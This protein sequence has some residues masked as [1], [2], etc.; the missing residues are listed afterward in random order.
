MLRGV[1]R[2]HG[3]SGEFEVLRCTEC[4]SARTLPYVPPESLGELYPDDYTAY[5]FPDNPALR[6][7]AVS[8]SEARYWRAVRSE[9][10]NRLRVGPRGRVLDVGSGRGDL[11]LILQR[12]GWD[13]LGLEP[14]G[15]A[16][17]EAAERGVPTVHATLQSAGADLEGPFD[18]V[19]FNHSLEH[20]T[21][22]IDD[23]RKARE[24]LRDGGE[25][26]VV[27]PNFGSWQRVRFGTFWF[28][29]DLPRHRSHFTQ[30][31]LSRLLGRAGFG[32]VVTGTTGTADGLPMSLQYRAF[33]RRRFDHG[34]GRYAALGA[35]LAAVPL[36]S[37]ANRLAGSGDIAHAVATK[38]AG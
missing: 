15:P 16:C 30:L 33:G 29:L 23:V 35:T 27:V 6:L 36:T 25:L 4:G 17:A 13:V 20:V 28:H 24:L 37:L 22:P 3:T 18:V 9:P 2:L 32:D 31:G 1:D 5:A 7:L 19:V 10:L 14:S 12:L 34:V 11:G 26:I 21:E 8:L 38:R